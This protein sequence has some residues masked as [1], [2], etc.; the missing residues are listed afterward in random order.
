MELNLSTPE[1]Y[2]EDLANRVG[3]IDE[4]VKKLQELNILVDRDDE[5]YLLQ[6]FTKP[7]V[8]RP[9]LLSKLFNEKV[10]LVLVMETL[11]PF[12]SLLNESRNFEEIFN[13]K[14]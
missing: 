2:Y 10:H 6:I 3:E 12:L 8:D 7:L 11:K 4:D 14:Y 9:T 13:S 5:G 1:T